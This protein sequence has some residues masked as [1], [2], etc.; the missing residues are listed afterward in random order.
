MRVRAVD[1]PESV[2]AV[3]RLHPGVEPRARSPRRGGRSTL[4]RMREH[5]PYVA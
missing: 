1:A 5:G 4:R 2:R 3:C